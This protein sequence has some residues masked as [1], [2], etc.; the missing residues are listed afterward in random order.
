MSIKN[1]HTYK[2]SYKDK[3]TGQI[4]ESKTL[5]YGVNL[6]AA[7]LGNSKKYHYRID[8]LDDK[9]CKISFYET[10]KNICLGSA[11]YTI[12]EA[13]KANSKVTSYHPINT[14]PS[15]YLFSKCLHRGWKRYARDLLSGLGNMTAIEMGEH[16]LD[17]STG[18]IIELPDA[19]IETVE[20]GLPTETKQKA[21]K[22]KT[23]TKTTS[24]ETQENA[25]T[26]ENTSTKESTKEPAK[27]TT[28][29]RNSRVKSTKSEV[30][31]PPTPTV[32]PE[33]KLS[34]EWAQQFKE[35]LIELGVQDIN[36]FTGVA[37]LTELTIAQAKALKAQAQVLQKD[38]EPNPRPNGIGAPIDPSD[39]IDDINGVK[40]APNRPFV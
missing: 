19:T 10:I 7:A 1:I 25:S 14:Y 15:D 13:K 8:Q 34:P 35:Q 22:S 3:A 11:E 4:K 40:P 33:D 38:F 29:P 37:D 21:T 16:D 20:T 5:I 26:K 9:V 24:K 30:V 6:I 2:R 31:T 39:T 18:E 17:I 36:A 23:S 32:N 27:T 12:T 28:R